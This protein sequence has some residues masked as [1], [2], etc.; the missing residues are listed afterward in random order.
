MPLIPAPEGSNPT[1]RKYF[2]FLYLRIKKGTDISA[3]PETI[4]ILN[5]N[6]SNI[7]PVVF[8]IQTHVSQ[9]PQILVCSECICDIFLFFA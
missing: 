3:V 4:L 1:L 5:Q 7:A 2:D 9:Y 6:V 8:T